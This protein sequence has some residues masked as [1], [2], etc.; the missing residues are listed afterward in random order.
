MFYTTFP[1]ARDAAYN[2]VLEQDIYDPSRSTD[3]STLHESARPSEYVNEQEPDISRT[4]VLSLHFGYSNHQPSPSLHHHQPSYYSPHSPV[5]LF[6]IIH[7]FELIIGLPDRKRGPRI[8]S[9]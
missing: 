2:A 4:S 7:I 8:C 9:V 5:S 1:A 6:F 3:Y